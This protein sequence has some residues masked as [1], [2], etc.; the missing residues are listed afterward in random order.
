MVLLGLCGLGR[1]VWAVTF[2][3]GSGL[4]FEHLKYW[5]LVLHR[6]ARRHSAFGTLHD[7]AM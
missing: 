6:G 3:E 5:A 1:T 7:L 4:C 2:A